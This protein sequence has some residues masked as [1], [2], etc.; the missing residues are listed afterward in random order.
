MTDMSTPQVRLQLRDFM[1]DPK[2]PDVMRKAMTL[3]ADVLTFEQGTITFWLHGV[4]VAS[5]TSDAV[6]AV[7]L[8]AAASSTAPRTYSVDKVRE[9]YGNAYQRWSRED[10]ELLV[11]LHAAGEVVDALAR[12]FARQ[13]SAI[14]SRLVKLG[15]GEPPAAGQ[16]SADPP[17]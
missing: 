6:S 10:D 2:D 1:L 14:R 17:F 3:E 7:E 4:E 11:E 12:R 9:R 16:P 13:P 8:S 5:F 15:V